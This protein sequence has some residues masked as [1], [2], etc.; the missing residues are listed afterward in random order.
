[1]KYLLFFFSLFL[2]T[3]GFSQEKFR[4]GIIKYKTNEKVN[5]TYPRLLKYVAEQL[6]KEVQVDIV[7]EDELA[8]H[9]NNGA[10]DIG[11]FTV[12][13]YLKAKT[14]F[15]ELHVFATHQ[16]GGKDHFYGSILVNRNSEIE[17][18][19]GLEGKDFLF[20]KPTS[21]SGYKYPKGI[22]TELSLDLESGFM[23]YD[24]SG[25]HEEAILALKDEKI[26]GIAVDEGRFDKIE[27]VSKSDFK[28]LERYKVPHHA[29]VFSPKMDTATRHKIL[30]VFENAHKDPATKELFDNPLGVEQWLPVQDEYYNLIRRYLRITRIKP[31]VEFTITATENA[32]KKLDVLG[33]ITTVM[34]G[35]IHRELNESQRFAKTSS[36]D[37]EFIGEILIASTA[38]HFS[39]Q[40]KVNGDFVTDGLVKTDSLEAK[41]P[42]A[43]AEAMLK[44]SEVETT[45]IYNGKEWFVTFGKNDGFDASNY[46]F[47]IIDKEGRSITVDE[48][49][50]KRVDDLNIIFEDNEKFVKGGLVTIKYRHELSRSNSIPDEEE[51]YNVFSKRFW[52][53]DSWDK[54]GVVLGALFAILSAVVGKVLTDRK[55]KRFKNILHQTNN[56][57]KEYVD[58]HIKMETRL[59]EQK[60]TIGNALEDGHINENQFLILKHRIEDLQNLVDFQRT[61][62]INLSE[63]DQEEIRE[64]IS[65]GQIKEKE[66]S[67]IMA[68]L[69]KNHKS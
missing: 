28:E 17:D 32:Q 64:I 65:D 22:F 1:M 56:L 62:S 55:K 3:L 63:K 26:D 11:I 29:Y 54:I 34:S 43:F 2:A 48:S 58:G 59:I 24:F 7:P 61:D 47:E 30:A 18:L 12:F 27:G 45:L 67:R 41:I 31:S 37:P 68:M 20:V 15:P 9:L 53:S 5:A 69:N 60:D 23:N 19:S 8:F 13:P 38:D 52:K 40:I 4:V 33:D 57:I 50:V 6:G 51:T 36:N 10:F 49:G 39:Y 16:V 66:F 44:S 42:D 46:I 35:R 21:T 14:D 25:G